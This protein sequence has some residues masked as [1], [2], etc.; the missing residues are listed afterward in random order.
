MFVLDVFHRHH[1]PI[2]ATQTKCQ[3]CLIFS[4][5]FFIMQNRMQQTVVSLDSWLD[6]ALFEG[7]ADPVAHD[8]VFSVADGGRALDVLHASNTASSHATVFA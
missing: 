6:E 4:Q 1:S 7:G 5:R 2:T 8:G 3:K